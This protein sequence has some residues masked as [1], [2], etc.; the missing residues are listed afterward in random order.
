MAYT[1]IT[2]IIF[3]LIVVIVYFAFPVKKYQWTVLLAASYV[4]YLWASWRVVAFLLITT[5]TVYLAA[6]AMYQNIEKARETVALHKKEWDREQKKQYK[7]EM[8]KKRRRIL[9]LVLVLNFGILAFLKYFNLLA[10]GLNSVLCAA[11]LAEP[12]PALQLFLPLGISFYTFQSTG[13]LIDVYREKFEPERNPAKFALF[14]SFFPQI[15]QG[16]ISFYDQLAHQLYAEHKFEYKNL[17]HGIELIIWGYLKKMVIADRAVLLINTV[18][19][20]YTQYNGTVI[21][22]TVLTYAL[23]LYADFSGGIDISRGLAEIMGIQMA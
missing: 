19:A 5:F 10:G 2:F 8:K 1:T 21:F 20:D 17:K 14:V 23:Q 4:F 3:A 11:G 15:I 7:E 16:P 6:L 12:I 18:T 13:Y 9:V 22:L